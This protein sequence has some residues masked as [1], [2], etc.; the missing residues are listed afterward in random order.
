MEGKV[1]QEQRAGTAQ[2]NTAAWECKRVAAAAAGGSSD[3]NTLA[4]AAVGDAAGTGTTAPLAG[5]RRRHLAMETG[6]EAGHA[7]HERR[8]NE[9]R[10]GGTCW[11]PGD[12]WGRERTRRTWAAVRRTRRR[13]EAVSG[14]RKEDWMLGSAEHHTAPP[15]HC[16][17]A[18]DDTAAAF[19]QRDGDWR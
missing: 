8:E 3:D 16:G 19:A 1:R 14:A 13:R 17:C 6:Q 4:D 18:C 2:T 7:A 11:R 10:R 15:L 9:R 5:G 12:G